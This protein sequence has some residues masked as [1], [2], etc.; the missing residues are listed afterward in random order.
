MRTVLR[1]LSQNI[2]L[3]TVGKVEES[4]EGDLSQ[5]VTLSTV[6]V[7]VSVFI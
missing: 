4:F 3:I 7:C 1:D 2:I 5:N 6:G